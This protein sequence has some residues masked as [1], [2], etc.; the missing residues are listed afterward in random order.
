MIIVTRRDDPEVKELFDSIDKMRVDFESIERPTLEIELLE[1]KVISSVKL[2]KTLTG[3]DVPGEK[4]AS[5]KE[6]AKKSRADASNHPLLNQG[7]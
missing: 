7:Q 4:V 3:G 5:P 2:K 6:K 1:E